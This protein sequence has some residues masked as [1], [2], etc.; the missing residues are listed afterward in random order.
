MKSIF[1]V[2]VFFMLSLQLYTDEL[3]SPPAMNSE[4]GYIV[5]KTDIDIPAGRARV[6][7]LPHVE[8]L[9]LAEDMDAYNFIYVTG[10]TSL[11]CYM[12]KYAKNMVLLRKTKR[13]NYISF[14]GALELQ[15]VPFRLYKG[16]ELP[17]TKKSDEA[18]HVQVIRNGETIPLILSRD[19]EG[20]RF[21][22]RSVF[23]E[24]AEKQKKKGLAYYKGKWLP[25][26]LAAAMAAEAE[27][28]R[29]K[30]K[31][32]QE[33]LRRAASEGFVVLNNGTVLRGRMTGSNGTHILFESEE[34]DYYL[35]IDDIAHISF[36]EMEARSNIDMALSLLNKAHREIRNDRGMA[37][38][39]AGEA[40]KYLD[41]VEK[42]TSSEY[43]K[44]EKMIT[45]ISALIGDLDAELAEKNEAVYKNTVFPADVLEYHIK[46][47]DILLHRKFWLKPGQLCPVC[48]AS[49][50][51]TCPECHG[52]GK[53]KKDCPYCEGGRIV[54]PLCEGRGYR[55][56]GMCGGKGY[57]YQEQKGTSIT[58]SFGGY[59]DGGYYPSYGG[60]T[61]GVSRGGVMII[62]PQ[63][64]FYPQY[65]G[66][67]LSV[68]S[69]NETVKTVCPEC[70]GRGIIN[71][72]KTVKCT[73]CDGK[74]YFIETCP[75]CK[76]KKKIICK[77]CGG[78]GFTGKVQTMP[79]PEKKESAEKKGHNYSTAPVVL[80]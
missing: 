75:V 24:F 31:N 6:M 67:Y 29:K 1:H 56:C 9:I 80:P 23:A 7:I 2:A 46:H 73:Y 61:I 41:K 72:P 30:E 43:K 26:K 50:F 34:N 35:G 19:T 15:T 55:E 57:I 27:A 49:G 65:H 71:C 53:V 52:A 12:P 37:L 66:T 78:K 44:A 63:T 18:Y 48:H 51:L 68:G 64:Y 69:G 22:I 10:G 45:E 36:S 17:V 8:L 74:G 16:E 39:H 33:S 60:G 77:A 21:S 47:G 32:L 25:E 4:I 42:N 28:S 62:Q 38:F 20:L 79:E 13:E 14:R 76:G 70:H 5:V 54:C 40:L 11:C 58:A 59:C 3:P